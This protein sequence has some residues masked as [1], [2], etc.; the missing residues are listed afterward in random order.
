MNND[1]FYEAK[2]KDKEQIFKLVRDYY[3][4]YHD[5]KQF[6]P[7]KSY[8]KASGATYNDEEMVNIVDV[9]LD[10]WLTEGTKTATLA[11][12]LRQLTGNDYCSLTVSGSSA[13]LLTFSA[14]TS[15][16]LKD[17]RILPGDEVITAACGFPTTINPIIQNRAIPVFVDIDIQTLNVLPETIEK[18]ISKRTKAIMIAHTLGFPMHIKEIRQIADK[19]NLWLIEDS[20]DA[21]GAQV[22]GKNITTFGDVATVSFFPAHQM[23]TGE[24][25][26][27]FTNDALLYR[28]INTFRDWGRDCWCHPGDDNTCGKRFSWQLGKLPHG[29]DHKYIYSEIG[30]NMRMTEMQAAI[31]VAQ[32]DKLTTFIEK[33]RQNFDYLKSKLVKYQDHFY[34][35]QVSKNTTPS[36]FGYIVILKPQAGFTR[37]E[38][39]QYLESNKVA[40]RMIF[41]GNILRQPAYRY[42]E[43]KVVGSLDNSDYLMDNAIWI[44]IHPGT[45]KEQLDYIVQVFDL[46][47]VDKKLKSFEHHHKTVTPTQIVNE[48]VD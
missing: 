42:I 36:P 28:L 8:I 46:F 47:M 30:Y 3:R 15:D 33:R 43:H 29:Y 45:T 12:K 25:G 20:C 9:A 32:V 21:L 35:I 23:T 16:R 44:A 19:H 26:A 17:R 1:P 10:F 18:A 2:K 27:I 37:E 5:S 41:G 39:V 48:S 14:L 22:E 34:E 6:F 11:H 40:T 13:N 4:N 7:G 24:G 31:G 38:L